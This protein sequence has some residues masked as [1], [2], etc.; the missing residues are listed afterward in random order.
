MV[1]RIFFLGL[2]LREASRNEERM[3]SQNLKV[4]T[5]TSFFAQCKSK[6]QTVGWLARPL[7]PQAVFSRKMNQVRFLVY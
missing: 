4:T 3:Q 7:D 6:V 2:F 5:Y 1:Q